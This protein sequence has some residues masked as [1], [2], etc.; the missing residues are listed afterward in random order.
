[1]KPSELLMEL[2]HVAEALESTTVSD[3][4]TADSSLTNK[5]AEVHHK[6][7][8]SL[9]SLAMSQSINSS[10]KRRIDKSKKDIETLLDV[11]DVESGVE[12]GKSSLVFEDTQFVLT[13]KRNAKSERI[14]AKDLCI[15]LTKLGVD[16][17]T[18]E[19]AQKAAKKETEGALF[20]VVGANDHS[21]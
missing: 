16:K 1:M 13:K 10:M 12:S 18:I 9:A 11:I 3:R 21:Q 7:N 5:E 2:A 6:L 15:E 17:K 4:F 8:R 20:Y 19:K 14:N